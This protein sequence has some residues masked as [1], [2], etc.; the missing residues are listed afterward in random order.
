MGDSL[1]IVVVIILAATTMFIFPMMAM[2]ERN[3]DVAQLAVNTA[4]TEF[5]NTARNTG[6]ITEENYDKLI[7]DLYATGNTYNVE[8]EIKVID[9]NPSRKK[10]GVTAGGDG[11]NRKVGESLYFSE[12]T[13]Q[14]MDEI[15]DKGY[16]LM[17]EGDE[18]IVKASNT[19]NTISQMLKNFFY[20]ISGNDIYS[21]VGQ[22]SGTVTVTGTA[23]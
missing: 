16:K 12:Y 1:T 6:K 4:I 9:A 10:L 23:K 14:I 13:S 17:K 22:H 2:S 7:T 18:L 20:S 11:T 5:V 21:I 19:N 3:D 8:I 15:D